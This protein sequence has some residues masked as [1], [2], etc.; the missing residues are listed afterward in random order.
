MCR[1]RKDGCFPAGNI[2][3]PCL[4]L[5]GGG[6]FFCERRPFIAVISRGRGWSEGQDFD[7]PDGFR[8]AASEPMGVVPLGPGHQGQGGAGRV[9]ERADCAELADFIDAYFCWAAILLNTSGLKT[10]GGCPACG[11]K[12]SAA[13][14]L[15]AA[16]LVSPR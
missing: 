15:S 9:T 3:D 2:Q 6:L 4:N 16:M 1:L 11:P 8:D 14:R 12:P 5:C 7:G 13:M 10:A